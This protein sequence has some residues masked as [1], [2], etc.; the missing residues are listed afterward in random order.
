MPSMTGWQ[1]RSGFHFLAER[2]EKAPQSCL[3]PNV[4]SEQLNIS[5]TLKDDIDMA[6][7]I[8]DL[9]LGDGN[10]GKHNRGL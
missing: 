4:V 8:E 3:K 6:Q 5:P 1:S 9:N 10:K 2:P 7:K